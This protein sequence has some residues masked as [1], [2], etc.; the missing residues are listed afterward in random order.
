MRDYGV[1]SPQYRATANTAITQ[2]T[3]SPQSQL[4]RCV[5]N[6]RV[7]KRDSPPL[8]LS[9]KSADPCD[10]VRPEMLSPI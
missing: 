3:D 10:T 5:Y 4:L 9:S 1:A 6:M 7:I 2:G 8:T